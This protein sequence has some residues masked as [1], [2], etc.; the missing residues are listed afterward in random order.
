[1][2]D[3]NFGLCEFDFK[4]VI[5]LGKLEHYTSFI[6]R[7]CDRAEYN[8]KRKKEADAIIKKLHDSAKIKYLGEFEKLSESKG[9]DNKENQAVPIK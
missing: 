9:K 1:M 6:F 7:I 2:K 4:H 3:A 8:Q 5:F